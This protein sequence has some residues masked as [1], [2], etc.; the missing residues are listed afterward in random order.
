MN[1]LSV[2]DAPVAKDATISVEDEDA[3]AVLTLIAEDPDET[4]TSAL[5]FQITELPTYGTLFSGGKIVEIGT[6]V[7]PE[8]H[9]V[10]FLCEFGGDILEDSFVFSVSD[11]DYAS[12]LG[13]IEVNIECQDKPFE[14]SSGVLV[15]YWLI[16]SL[17]VIQSVF[18][19]V[20][21]TKHKRNIVVRLASY[22]FS[23]TGLIFSASGFIY[24]ALFTSQKEWACQLRGLALLFT[25]G[26]YCGMLYFKSLRI[27]KLVNN[28]KFKKIRVTDRALFLKFFVPM[29]LVVIALGS[30]I[31]FLGTDC[32]LN[33]D[34]SAEEGYLITHCKYKDWALR[35]IVS[36]WI[37]GFAALAWISW[38]VRHAPMELNDANHITVTVFILVMFFL[39]KFPMA[40]IDLDSPTV[41]LIIDG[42][43]F[44]VVLII[45]NLVLF[46]AKIVHIRQMDTQFSSASGASHPSITQTTTVMQTVGDTDDQEI[47]RY[48]QAVKKTSIGSIPNMPSPNKVHPSATNKSRISSVQSSCSVSSKYS[49]STTNSSYANNTSNGGGGGKKNRVR[50]LST[51]ND[52]NV[53]VVSQ[54]NVISP[55]SINPIF[56]TKNGTS[57]VGAFSVNAAGNRTAL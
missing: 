57:S 28:K 33:M 20:S 55:K 26:G 14:M 40:F 22:R 53:T 5:Q 50:V 7:S 19:I 44:T 8:V 41:N 35:L 3:E 29:F 12:S 48:R 34:S 47:A 32:D 2:N 17:L 9:F 18:L 13:V 11:S 24:G 31:S 23:V 15:A 56:S 10:P 45:C 37:C 6:D 38:K 51:R 46:T 39:F 27:S 25:M 36:V 30:I 49:T 42:I 21:F 1:V 16:A 54:G 52:K 43:A 4:T